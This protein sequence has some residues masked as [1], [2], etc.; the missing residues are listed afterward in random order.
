MQ[1]GQIQFLNCPL[2]SITMDQTVEQ[3]LAWSRSPRQPHLLVT[4]N[5]N[6]LVT[7]RKDE[8]L[9]TACVTADLTVADG[10][11]VVWACNWLNTPVKGRVAGVDLL[12]RLLEVG[13][14]HQLRVYF[15]GAKLEVLKQL[16]KVCQERYPG[17]NIVGYHDG[18]FNES[19]HARI[20]TEIRNSGADFLFIGMP[21]PFKEIWGH[22][23]KTELN[24]PLIFGVGG[25]FDVLAGFVRRAPRWM[26]HIGMEWFW[27]V[28]ME[29]RKLWKRHLVCNSTFIWLVL[30]ELLSYRRIKK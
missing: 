29:P 19:E 15:L 10:M 24:I 7:M 21:T 18:Y 13:S 26:Q 16:I 3:C 12:T 11:P 25:S 14:Q 4:I 17:V 30:Y 2:N 28:M 20:V 5:A 27:R 23:Y 8:Q 1:S 9:R 6:T 22:R